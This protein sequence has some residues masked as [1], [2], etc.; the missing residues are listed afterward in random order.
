MK[1]VLK[2]QWYTFCCEEDLRQAL[3]HLIVGDDYHIWDTEE[4]ARREIAKWNI[5]D[6]S[7]GL[8]LEL[9]D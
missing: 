2:G 9:T 7:K 5:V 4:E 1:H 6:A 8:T 3:N